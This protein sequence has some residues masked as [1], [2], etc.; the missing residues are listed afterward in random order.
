MYKFL[1]DIAGW[2]QNSVLAFAERSFA[3]A[4]ANREKVDSGFS[5]KD[6]RQKEI[7]RVA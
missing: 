4:R 1:Q 5:Q 7:K 3:A 2:R 6:V